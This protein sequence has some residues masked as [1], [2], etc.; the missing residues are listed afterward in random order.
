MRAG[1][2]KIKSRK[3]TDDTSVETGSESTTDDTVQLQKVHTANNNEHR[4]RKSENIN[5]TGTKSHQP[6][7][8]RGVH[9]PHR[10]FKKSNSRR[11]GLFE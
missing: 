9:W 7:P 2:S 1:K 11:E 4:M 5:H 6:R 8:K 10:L 3:R